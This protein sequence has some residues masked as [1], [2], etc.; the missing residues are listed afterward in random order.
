[1]N[2]IEAIV[3]WFFRP[4]PLGRIAA[5]R[6][7]A[8][9]FIPVDLLVSASWVV[10]HK[11]VPTE[12]YLPLNFTD[13][14]PWPTPTHA[15]V[16]TVFA[17]LLILCIPA[18]LNIAPRLL[19]WPLAILYFEWM[20][21]A[22][23]YGKVDH[24]RFGY[25]ILLF[26]LPTIGKAKWGDTKTLSPAAGWAVVVTQIGVVCTYFLA[27]W[28]KLRFGGIDWVN[29]ATITRAVVRRGT[30]F[31][32][33]M[34]DYPWML[35]ASQYGIFAFEMLSPIVLF[36][37][38]RWQVFAVIGFYLFHVVVYATI[39]IIFLPHLVAMAAFLPLEKVRPIVWLRSRFSR[40][41]VATAQ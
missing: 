8:Y 34:L 35:R 6:T 21:I 5:L 37:K 41:R 2:P 11:D 36:L 3:N 9:L 40:L 38:P 7:L 16:V 23:S 39:T 24:D 30:F 17:A 29:S 20:V 4:I 1:M 19:G 13:V 10:Q 32:E 31:S 22:M 28:A 27:A 26:V 12:L 18:A 15:V 33:W 14:I 25:M